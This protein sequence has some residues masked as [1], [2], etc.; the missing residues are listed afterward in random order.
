[1]AKK[2]KP[3]PEGI[4]TIADNRRARRDWEIT[5]TWEAGL[6][7]KGTEVKALRDRHVNFS[8]AYALLKSG[9]VYLI[10]L[11]IEPYSH[12]THENHERERERRLLLNRNE[13]DRLFKL[14]AERGLT[15]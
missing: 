7:L 15:A 8:D 5:D 13:I 6:E 4:E 10:G 12:G 11:V 2:K 14:T 9:Q 3:D 1:M